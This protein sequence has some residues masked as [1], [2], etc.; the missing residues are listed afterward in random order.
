MNNWRFPKVAIAIAALVILG[1]TFFAGVWYGYDSRPGA[2][3][4]A[5]ILHKEQPRNFQDVDF[6]L[7]WDVW[8][9]LE[10]K[11]VDSGKIDRQK[12]VFGAIQGLTRSLGDPYTEFLPPAETKQFREDIKGSF[13]GIGAEIGIRKGVLTIISPLKGSPAEKTGIKAGDKVFKINDTVTAD[14]AL[15]EA[16]RMIRGPKG[17]E[18]RLTILRD[19]FAKTK[20]FSIIRDTIK[21]Q[22]LSTEKKENGIFVIK[23]NSFTESAGREFRKA[24]QEYFDSGSTKLILDLRNNPGGFLTVAVDIASWFLPP[25]ETVVHE[26]YAD[27]SEDVYRSGGYRLMEHVPM[28]VL[29]NEGS[30]SASEIVAGA[31]RDAKGVKLIGTKTFGKGSVQEVENLARNSSLKITIAKWLTPKGEEINGKGLEPDVTV[32]LPKEENGNGEAPEKDVIMEKGI[33]MIKGL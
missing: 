14:L 13:D 16:V 26:R 7:F 11:Y 9:R 12:L 2:E 24:L 32:E 29:V 30:A 6:D 5:N 8:S 21:V 10:E 1:A 28:V 19:S 20:E 27:G 3:R 31:L 22:I 33:E 23:L 15:D 18:V 25:G 4:V 17:T